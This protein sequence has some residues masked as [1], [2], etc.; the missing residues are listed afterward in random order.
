MPGQLITELDSNIFPLSTLNP[1]KV[2]IDEFQKYFFIH[3]GYMWNF[4]T[5]VFFF[6]IPQSIYDRI[7]SQLFL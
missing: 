2:L 1:V 6:F 4:E 7:V 5:K 3:I